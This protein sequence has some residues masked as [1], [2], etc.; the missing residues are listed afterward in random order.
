M[1]DIELCFTSCCFCH[2][3][4]SLWLLYFTYRYVTGPAKIGHIYTQ[5]LTLFVNLNLQ[6]LLKYKC[7]YN[8]TL[9]SYSQINKKAKKVYKTLL[10]IISTDQEKYYFPNMCIFCRYARFS[11]AQSH[12]G[13]YITHNSVLTYPVTV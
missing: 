7:Y 10:Y 11:Q 2:L 3:I 12:I 4:P 13:L 1:S 9:M 6:Y 5:N 8:Q